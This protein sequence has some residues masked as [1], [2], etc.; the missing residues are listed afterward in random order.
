M[1]PKQYVAKPHK[2]QA[3][4]YTAGMALPAGVDDCEVFP[5]GGLHAHTDAGMKALHET[6]W[7][8]W[9]KKG[10]RL[11]DVMTDADFIDEFGQGGGPPLP[12]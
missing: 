4:Q 12:E 7:L 1:A 6:D 3:E 2:V 11:T 8:V 10:G 9:D 5:P